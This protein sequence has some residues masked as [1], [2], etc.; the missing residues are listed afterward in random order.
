VADIIFTRCPGPCATMT[1]RM[2]E[3]QD[4]LPVD[5]RIRLV[6]LTTD[7]DYDSPAM[8]AAYARRFG[9]DPERW[10]FLT[11]TKEQ[12]RRLAVEGLKLA[13][14]EKPPETREQPDD[15]FIHSTLLV[16][17]DARGRLRAVFESIPRVDEDPEAG[18][19]PVDLDQAFQKT[20]R[21][22][23]KTVAQL[24]AEPSQ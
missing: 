3:L 6:S 19:A 5:E 23:L 13:V 16:V 11:G 10:Q 24:L 17:V 1:R 15:L 7:P 2:R 18:A 21:D 4:A 8:L 14:V 22:V 9:A 12:L 20:K